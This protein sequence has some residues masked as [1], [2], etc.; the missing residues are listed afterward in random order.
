MTKKLLLPLILGASALFSCSDITEDDRF[1]KVDSVTPQRAVLLEEFTGQD[2]RNCPTA[3]R[4]LAMLI[5]Q[6]PDN[7][8]PV[9]IHAGDFGVSCATRRPGIIGLMQPEGK[10]YNDRYGIDEWPKGVIDGQGEPLNFDKWSDALRV[11]LTRPASLNIDIAASIAEAT[12]DVID[13][14]CE[15]KPTADLN[16][17]LYI[18]VLEDCIVAYQ[19]DNGEVIRDYVHNHVYRAAANGVE[20][21]TVSLK[22]N[23]HSTLECST[24]VRA[25][26]KETWNTSNLSIVAFVREAD[27]SVAQTARCHVALPASS[28]TN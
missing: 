14:K 24:A 15:L 18:W 22:A 10:K 25:T 7:L 9:S 6:Y 8:I 17:T 4:E 1:I 19:I 27:G 21:Q 13:I 11:A 23:I 26:E 12:P 20:G 2:C 28:E 3:H 5:E 16:G